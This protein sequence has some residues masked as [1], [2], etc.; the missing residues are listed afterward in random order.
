MSYPVKSSAGLRV[1]ALSMAAMV[2][3]SSPPS[4]ACP[5]SRVSCRAW[6]LGE[7]TLQLSHM[8]TFPSLS[9]LCSGNDKSA[10]PRFSHKAAH[11]R[12]QGKQTWNWGEQEDTGLKAKAKGNSPVG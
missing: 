6:T 10:T 2:V 7:L 11:W 4:S 5:Q 1:G 9:L 12:A 3:A 8:G